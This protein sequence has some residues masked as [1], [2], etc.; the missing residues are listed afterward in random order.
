M[1][2]WLNNDARINDDVRQ[3]PLIAHFSRPPF[4]FIITQMEMMSVPNFFLIFQQ[5]TMTTTAMTKCQDNFSFPILHTSS[6][7]SNGKRGGG[8][9]KKKSN[10]KVICHVISIS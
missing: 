9:L 10:A 7:K 2:K 1:L 8:S 3:R 4:F 5:A 6:H